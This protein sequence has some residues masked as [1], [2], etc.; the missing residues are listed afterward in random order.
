MKWR[1]LAFAENSGARRH[2]EVCFYAYI[3][4]VPVRGKRKQAR[5]GKS[6][7]VEDNIGRLLE[8]PLN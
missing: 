1:V 4:A 2:L 7:R 3:P 5:D 8:D 6:Q